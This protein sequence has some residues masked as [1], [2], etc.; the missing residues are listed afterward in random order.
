M[1]RAGG[2]AELLGE[3]KLECSGGTPGLSTT[4]FSIALNLNYSGRITNTATNTTEAVLIV[5]DPA[6]PVLGTN[7]FQGVLQAPNI[8]RFS[9]V[10]LSPPGPAGKLIIRVAN[11]RVD[12]GFGVAAPSPAQVLAFVSTSGQI[13]IPINN[14]QQTLGF[15]TLGHR[16][17]MTNPADAP[18]TALD[19]SG[20]GSTTFT[21]RFDESFQ[22]AFRKRN[23]AT[24][25][26]DPNA[27][28]S[29][30]EYGRDYATESGFYL[31]L[32]NASDA[33]L[34]T[35]GT[36][37]MANFTNLPTGVTLSASAQSIASTV[38][39]RLISTNP[40][41]SGPY[42]AITPNPDGTAP[43]TISGGAARAVWEILS[44]DPA[45]LE[46]VQFNLVAVSTAAS[47]GSAGVTCQFAPTSSQGAADATSPIPRFSP[48]NQ[49]PLSACGANC[50]SVPSSLSVVHTV[51][52]AAPG[53]I[54][55]PIRS[56]GGALTF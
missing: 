20:V 30:A 46:N 19:F 2:R 5:G 4:D 42:T 11:L 44:S 25:P 10:Q 48:L 9:G 22:N 49:A 53:P 21:L 50:L 23:V 32:L 1:I 35:H 26:A 39:A 45:A 14:P 40:D 41:G 28:A 29:Q 43:L 15:I 34:A 7:V 24:T 37:L 13:S 38:Q 3:F 27:L 52:A 47:T 33:G 18:V 16:F 12:D 55:I 31:P 54:A 6:S 56:T 36:R 17:Q 51:G 8:I